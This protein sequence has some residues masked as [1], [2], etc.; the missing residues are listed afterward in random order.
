VYCSTIRYSDGVKQVVSARINPS[1]RN[2]ARSSEGLEVVVVA[3]DDVV[4]DLLG[5]MCSHSGCQYRRWRALSS[6]WCRKDKGGV[7]R[8]VLCPMFQEFVAFEN[9]HQCPLLDGFPQAQYWADMLHWRIGL[10][11]MN[12]NSMK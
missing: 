9:K 1:A 7:R 5:D 4:D 6:C 8:G 2:E 12:M 3:I 10:L 11:R